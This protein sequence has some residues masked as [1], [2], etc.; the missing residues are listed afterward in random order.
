MNIVYRGGCK[1]T[2]FAWVERELLRARVGG[3]NIFVVCETP[4]FERLSLDGDGVVLPSTHSGYEKRVRV[5]PSPLSS[6]PSAVFFAD[7]LFPRKRNEAR[8]AY[9]YVSPRQVLLD[10]YSM[11]VFDMA[12]FVRRYGRRP[13]PR[14]ECLLILECIETLIQMTGASGGMRSVSMDMRKSL[15]TRYPKKRFQNIARTICGNSSLTAGCILS[16]AAG[17]L[18]DLIIPQSNCKE[19]HGDASVVF[20][21]SD[22]LG[23]SATAQAVALLGKSS[24]FFLADVESY[25]LKEIKAERRIFTESVPS[26]IVPDVETW[27]ASPDA[28]ALEHWG[29]TLERIGFKSAQNLPVENPAMLEPLDCIVYDV[30]KARFSMDSVFPEWDLREPPKLRE[31]VDS[32]LLVA[33]R[34]MDE[35]EKEI[36]YIGAGNILKMIEEKEKY[37]YRVMNIG[38]AHKMAIEE[39]YEREAQ[40]LREEI[41]KKMELEARKA[42]LEQIEDDNDSDDDDMPF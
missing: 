36:E 27:G 13:T 41:D 12:R 7:A 38:V 24:I 21:L 35:K 29:R 34:E 17:A 6:S 4:L 9:W 26:S 30:S 25:E 16:I 19:E 42:G 10:V 11:C 18:E 23:E 39:D 33:L 15:E 32:P 40:R 1:V 2:K 14:E 8:E 37:K 20:V 5:I 31:S 22:H 3:G 28:A